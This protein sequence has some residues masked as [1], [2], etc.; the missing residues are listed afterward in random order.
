[1][2][3][4][5]QSLIGTR[6]VNLQS[7]STVSFAVFC[8]YALLMLLIDGSIEG[9]PIITRFAAACNR[10]A[11]LREAGHIKFPRQSGAAARLHAG[12]A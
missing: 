6:D 2:A 5:P 1:M 7:C 11:S 10:K 12:S 3:A 4:I 9:R 8:R